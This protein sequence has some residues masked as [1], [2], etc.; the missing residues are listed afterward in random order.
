MGPKQAIKSPT[1]HE[2][3]KSRL[4]KYGLLPMASLW[5]RYQSQWL[6]R[7]HLNI[8]P[9]TLPIYAVE[10]LWGAEGHVCHTYWRSGCYRIFNAELSWLKWKSWKNPPF[11]GQYWRTNQ[12]LERR[13]SILSRAARAGL[14]WRTGGQRRVEQG[15]HGRG[16]DPR[17]SVELLEKFLREE[18]DTGRVVVLTTFG[19]WSQRTLRGKI[20][21]EGSDRCRTPFPVHEGCQ[22]GPEETPHDWKPWYWYQCPRDAPTII[23]CPLSCITDWQS[24]SSISSSSFLHLFFPLL[25]FCRLTCHFPLLGCSP[26][27]VDSLDDPALFDKWHLQFITYLIALPT[28]SDP[29]SSRGGVWCGRGAYGATFRVV[30]FLTPNI[31]ILS[32]PYTRF[33]RHCTHLVCSFEVSWNSLDLEFLLY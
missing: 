30:I 21:D 19:T 23:I 24:L 9:L 12:G 31:I 17:K 1:H 13:S 32:F 20:P 33:C 29:N 4:I 2:R 7:F 27:L 14:H 10:K 6:R 25:S 18:P 11:E 16:K 26:R 22:A 5:R 15:L 28:M 8:G 3:L